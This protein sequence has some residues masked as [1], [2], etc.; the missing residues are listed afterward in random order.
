M[1]STVRAVRRKGI[2]GPRFCPRVLP[3]QPICHSYT[4]RVQ[5][6]PQT[7]EVGAEEAGCRLDVF[8]AARLALSRAQTRRLLARGAVRVA[9]RPVAEGGKGIALRAGEKVEVE[10]FARPESARVRP[11][12]E[13]AL[14]VVAQ[15]VGWIAVDKPAGMPVHPLAPD[16]T[17]TVLNAAV[18][19]HPELQGVGEGA[20][21]SG[22]VHRLDV[23]TSGV[24]L[25]AT[26]EQAWQ[27]L[28]AAFTSQRVTK[29]YR[30]IALGRLEGE[31][32]VRVSLLTA[33]H[34]PA[35][36]RVARQG[37]QE[38]ARGARPAELRWRALEALADATLVE[39]RPTTGFLHQIRAI[40][41]EL[42][43]PLA[44]DR[45]YGPPADATGAARHMLHASE[46]DFE[47]ISA[48]AADA[49][50]FAALLASLRDAR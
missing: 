37:E 35:R 32:E 3:C 1:I 38:R 40:F 50:D 42:G 34:R 46:I 25:I 13:L 12:P 2:S 9:G 5:G 18:A 4:A 10:P 15:G 33:R 8:L 36:V 28:R 14:P 11:Q 39:V 45:T 31:G 17:G 21:R 23:D 49:P 27:R 29:V 24:L 41:A 7:L 43:H 6:G 16:E 20:L 26:A 30:A 19:R 48:R 47:E 44:G 22:V